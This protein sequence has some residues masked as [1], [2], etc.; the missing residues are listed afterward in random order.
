MTL[1]QAS[2]AFLDSVFSGRSTTWQT[3]AESFPD[4]FLDPNAAAAEEIEIWAL[5]EDSISW[6]TF[7]NEIL[8]SRLSTFANIAPSAKTMRQKVSTDPYAHRVFHRADG[9]TAQSKQYL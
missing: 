3:A 9:W 8:D 5:P 1:Q 2:A 7:D 4:L 6:D